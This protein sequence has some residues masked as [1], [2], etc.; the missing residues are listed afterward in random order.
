MIL[1]PER[2]KEWLV[3]WLQMLIDIPVDPQR[4]QWYRRRLLSEMESLEKSCRNS[5]SGLRPINQLTEL[6]K[7]L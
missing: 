7:W 6:R 1:K 3:L 5:P 4:D 2:Y